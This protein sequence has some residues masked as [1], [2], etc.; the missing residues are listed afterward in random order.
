MTSEKCFFIHLTD[1]E[2]K[3]LHSAADILRE[4]E[5]LAFCEYDARK[6]IGCEHIL[7]SEDDISLAHCLLDDFG[8]ARII[9][10]G[11]EELK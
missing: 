9:K 3:I 6:L 1:D 7:Y 4:I 2:A 8:F 5:D 11:E 10:E